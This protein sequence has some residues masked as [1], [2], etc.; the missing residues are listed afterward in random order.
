MSE[1]L[2]V[3]ASQFKEFTRQVF[4]ATG[5]PAE[6]AG[7]VSGHLVQANLMGYDSHG[8]IRVCQYVADTGDGRS[9][10]LALPSLCTIKQTQ[11]L[12][13]TAAGTSAKL[14]ATARFS[15]RW[16]KRGVTTFPSW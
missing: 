2:R 3:D 16:R 4:V 5:S 9:L 13:S 15:V 12:S 1:A 10:S 11:R 14:E 7:L 6:E 8:V